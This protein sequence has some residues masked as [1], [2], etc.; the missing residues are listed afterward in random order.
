MTV[1]RRGPLVH[2]LADRGLRRV[3]GALSNPR[4]KYTDAEDSSIT[5]SRAPLILGGGPIRKRG[6]PRGETFVATLLK[7]FTRE[8][9]V[10]LS[11]MGTPFNPPRSNKLDVAVKFA[12][13][14]RSWHG[15]TF[16]SGAAGGAA[17]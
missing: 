11:V 13:L 4:Q 16:S 8:A 9:E 10:L 3:A 12:A 6:L 14:I 1:I 17:E 7:T 5:R 15:G 2:A